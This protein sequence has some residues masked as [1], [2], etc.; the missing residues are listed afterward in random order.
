MTVFAHNASRG[1]N[2]IFPGQ[3]PSLCFNRQHVI[4][5]EGL[6]KMTHLRNVLN[7]LPSFKAGQFLTKDKGEKEVP[8]FLQF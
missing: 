7:H 8:Q 1:L 3:E 4:Q 6:M 5:Q 2:V